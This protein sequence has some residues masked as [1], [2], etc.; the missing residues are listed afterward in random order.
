MLGYKRRRIIDNKGG[1]LR[2]K[3]SHLKKKD[4]V[5]KEKSLK[6]VKKEKRKK[7]ELV[8]TIKLSCLSKE[9]IKP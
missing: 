9:L 6:K 3:L 2:L 8:L 1:V 7:E 4:G 5:K